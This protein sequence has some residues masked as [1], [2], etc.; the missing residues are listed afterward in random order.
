MRTARSTSGE[1]LFDLVMAPSSQEWE[2]P[3]NPGR[4]IEQTR[5]KYRKRAEEAPNDRTLAD[6][7]RDLGTDPALLI[8]SRRHLVEER[9]EVRNQIRV[10]AGLISPREFR[11]HQAAEARPSTV[12]E[13]ALHCRIG[14][15]RGY[16]DEISFTQKSGHLSVFH[17]N[18]WG[19]C[20][21]ARCFT[22]KTI[23]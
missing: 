17:P 15:V 10:L 5:T 2:P 23:L 12:Q 18:R 13:A 22:Q 20:G 11:R 8:E 14:W 6:E 9:Q 3:Q 4:F 1:N 16:G 21:W 7:V 19:F